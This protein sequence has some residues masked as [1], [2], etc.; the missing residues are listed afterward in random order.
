HANDVVL[1]PRQ[2]CR[3][4]AALAFLQ[5]QGFSCGRTLR[6]QGLQALSDGGPLFAF[7]GGRKQVDLRDDR[8][9]VK[10]GVQFMRGRSRGHASSSTRSATPCHRLERSPGVNRTSVA[11]QGGVP[12]TLNDEQVD[13]TAAKSARAR[14]NAPEPPEQDWIDYVIRQRRKR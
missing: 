11:M 1:H 13:A 14:R 3:A 6:E 10:Q 12:N 8:V 7:G 4:A 2:P 9:R 5:Q